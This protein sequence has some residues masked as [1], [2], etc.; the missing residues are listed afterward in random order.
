MS[1]CVIA[2]EE[3]LLTLDYCVRRYSSCR[4]PMS[5]LALPTLTINVAQR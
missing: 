2:S 4:K 1:V 5:I 3:M